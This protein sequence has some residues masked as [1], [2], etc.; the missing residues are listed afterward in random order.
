MEETLT[1]ISESGG[2]LVVLIP[3]IVQI[4]KK[5]PFLVDMQKTIP[6]YQMLSIGLGVAG[7]FSLGLSAPIITGIVAGL[8]AGKAFDIVKGK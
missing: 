8:A 1:Q 4:F 6:I 7:A 5:V 2:I 3:S